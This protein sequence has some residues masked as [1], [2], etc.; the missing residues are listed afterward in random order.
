VAIDQ[1]KNKSPFIYRH[2][3]P[4]RWSPDFCRINLN[5]TRI[6]NEVVKQ[7]NNLQAVEVIKIIESYKDD[8][9][10]FNLTFLNA[11]KF[12]KILRNEVL[13]KSILNIEFL[14][15]DLNSALNKLSE[16]K[17]KHC[18]LD[19]T[20]CKEE[21]LAAISHPKVRA[22]DFFDSKQKITQTLYI[23][24]AKKRVN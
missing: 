19:I 7:C 9:Y 22:A 18:S 5:I 6:D 15:L 13:P 23:Q 24:E 11:N 4:E 12:S 3:L 16:I 21:I 2:L 17:S 20:S 1:L 14:G 8:N 10:R